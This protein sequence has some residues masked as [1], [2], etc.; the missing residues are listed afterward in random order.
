M[1]IVAEYPPIYDKIV[2]AVGKPP[3]TA[4]YTYGDTI[5]NPTGN[6]L[7]EFLIEHEK[8]HQLQQEAIG[9]PVNWWAEWLA[10]PLFRLVHEL[11]AYQAQYRAFAKKHKDRNDQARYARGLAS[12]LCGAMYG[13]VGDF[14]DLYKAIRG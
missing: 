2:E 8:V 6:E 3:E 9:G 7:D 4:V 1:N 5:Y 11:G 10:L 12:D 14:Q 13:H